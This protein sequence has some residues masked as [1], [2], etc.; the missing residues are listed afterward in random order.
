MKLRQL[1][2]AD[3]LFLVTEAEM[4]QKIDPS[5]YQCSNWSGGTTTQLAI[6]PENADFASRAFIYRISQADVNLESSTF[7]VFEGVSRFITTTEGRMRIRHDQGQW[8]SLEPYVVHRFSGEQLTESEGK[9]KDFNLLVKGTAKGDMVSHQLAPGD[10][11]G[12]SIDQNKTHLWLYI[13]DGKSDL[14]SSGDFFKATEETLLI[15]AQTALTIIVCN[16]QIK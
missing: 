4:W 14:G 10:E 3:C 16:I 9:V 1:L 12:W 15:K 7:T 6:W 5:Q 13:A 2:R 8:Y 11:L